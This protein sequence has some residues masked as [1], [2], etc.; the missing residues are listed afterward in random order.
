MIGVNAIL[1]R[2]NTGIVLTVPEMTLILRELLKELNSMKVELNELK[3][4]S[5]KP[6]VDKDLEGA[7]STPPLRRK[8]DK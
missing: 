8:L 1:N 2:L 4:S 5:H 3:V 7:L 6:G